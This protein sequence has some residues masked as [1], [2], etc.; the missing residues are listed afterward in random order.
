[1]SAYLQRLLGRAAPGG[2]IAAV[3]PSVPVAP[4]SSPLAAHDQRLG[5]PNFEA[6]VPSEFDEPKVIEPVATSENRTQSSSGK[7]VAGEP[8]IRAPR[9]APELRLVGERHDAPVDAEAT[10]SPLEA[11]PVTPTTI[12]TS[13]FAPGPLDIQPNDLEPIQVSVTAVAG[14][15]EQERVDG[16]ADAPEPVSRLASPLLVPAQSVDPEFPDVAAETNDRAQGAPEGGSALPVEPASRQLVPIAPLLLDE[17]ERQPAPI[18]LTP[19]APEPAEKRANRLS[20]AFELPAEE[21]AATQ[22]VNIEQIVIDV[23]EPQQTRAAEG[24]AARGPPATAAAASIIGPLPV[25][26]S[27]VSLF[28]MRRR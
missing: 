27:T 19:D 5:L 3:P 2:A 20:P 7:L 11:A 28:G 13:A 1:M 26:R 16:P 8:S 10:P 24:L 17:A 12:D 25:R 21:Q 23:H 4:L 9:P 22:S 18:A 15:V 14:Q 6:P